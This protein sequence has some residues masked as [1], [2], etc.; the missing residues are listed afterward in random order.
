M[1]ARQR[2]QALTY[3]EVGQTRAG[4]LPAGYRH[5]R[6][7]A[8]IGYGAPAWARA[9]QAVASWQAHRG[10]GLGV[11]PPDAPISARTVL[12][13]SAHFG[14]LYLVLPCR[15]VY[16]TDDGRRFGFAYGTLPGHPESGEES[17]HVVCDDQDKVSF[18]V[19]AF[20]A[21]GDLATRLAGPVASLAQSRT[22]RR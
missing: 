14:P 20:S 19:V 21:P 15:I 10:A 5:Q 16:S 17:F 11:Y 1:L 2:E 8:V 12:L 3:A 7:A 6:A 13:A 22:T 4:A 9:K 18:E